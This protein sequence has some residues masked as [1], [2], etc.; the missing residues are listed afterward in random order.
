MAFTPKL[1]PMDGQPRAGAVSS[2]IHGRLVDSLPSPP[3]VSIEGCDRIARRVDARLWSW[4]DHRPRMRP[5]RM[6]PE[7]QSL[8]P[9]KASA[10]MRAGIPR[11]DEPA[12][13]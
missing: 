3:L 10:P 4:R 6:S 9:A 12:Q 7:G 5:M 2:P 1:H 13:K 11:A 8:A